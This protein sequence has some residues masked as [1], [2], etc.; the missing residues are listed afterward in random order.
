M[1]SRLDLHRELVGL[2][3]SNQVYFQPPESIR[4]TYPAI[5]YK[6]SNVDIKYA[7]DCKYK[8]MKRYD[9][10]LIDKNPDTKYVDDILDLPYCKFDRYFIYDNLNHYMFTLFY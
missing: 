7:D 2:L 5:V 1:T 10:T 9:I 6:L 8:R 4:M 3:G